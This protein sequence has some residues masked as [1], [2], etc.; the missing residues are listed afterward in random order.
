MVFKK[1]YQVEEK[2]TGQVEGWGLG[3]P[4]VAQ[5]M[6]AHGGSVRLESKLGKGT[7]VTL[8]FPL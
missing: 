6:K 4:F 5:A 8:V 7:T 2:F 1:F 3:L